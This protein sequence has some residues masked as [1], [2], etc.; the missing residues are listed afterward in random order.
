MLSKKRKM[1]I[2]IEIP[3]NVETQEEATQQMQ[4]IMKADARTFE[5][6]EEIIKVY[7]GTMCIEQKI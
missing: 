7:K 2:T 6:L 1:V 4:M 5:S 3:L